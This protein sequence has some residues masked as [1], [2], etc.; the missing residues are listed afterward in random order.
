MPSKL[1]VLSRM[2]DCRPL[3]SVGPDHSRCRPLYR[4]QCPWRPST[5]R[6]DRLRIHSDIDFVSIDT[7][8]HLWHLVC[9]GCPTCRSDHLLPCFLRCF[10]CRD[11]YTANPV[12]RCHGNGRWRTY[13]NCT[14]RHKWW[15]TFATARTTPSDPL[16]RG[17][18]G[19]WD[20]TGHWGRLSMQR[21]GLLV[22][23]R[24]EMLCRD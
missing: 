11:G 18:P 8:P 2:F 12:L 3:G 7:W 5:N 21:R 19:Q 1:T 10:S 9:E 20:C 4:V 13:D 24:P 6:V 15:D 22:S 16:V 14:D 17:G 23:R